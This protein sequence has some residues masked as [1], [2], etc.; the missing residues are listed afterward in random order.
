M[1]NQKRKFDQVNQHSN[2]IIPNR[3]RNA[4]VEMNR[5]NVSSAPSGSPDPNG[6][7]A[8]YNSYDKAENG[9]LGIIKQ[10]KSNIRLK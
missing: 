1:K 10:I 5:H 7:R 6:G 2:N 3:L 9:Y 4:D 8:Y